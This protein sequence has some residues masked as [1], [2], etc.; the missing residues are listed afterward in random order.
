MKDNLPR[1]ANTHSIQT[2]QEA[3]TEDGL[4]ILES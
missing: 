1:R 2:K 3:I 4:E